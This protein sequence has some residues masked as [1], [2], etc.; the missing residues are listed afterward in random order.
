MDGVRVALQ[1]ASHC[2]DGGSWHGGAERRDMQLELQIGDP[3]AALH[4]PDTKDSGLGAAGDLV[5]EDR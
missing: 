1:G 3:V 5:A 2:S 4:H